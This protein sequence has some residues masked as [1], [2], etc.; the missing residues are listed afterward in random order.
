MQ[1][2][3]VTTTTGNRTCSPQRQA[4]LRQRGAVLVIGLVMLTVTTMLV[5][6]MLKTS[7][8]DLKIGGVTQ[9]A[10]INLNNADVML[11][12]YFSQNTGTFSNRCLVQA[13]LCNAYTAPVGLTTAPQSAVLQ[14]TQIYCGDK[15]GFTGNQV[16]ITFQTAI[17]DASIFITSTL[18]NQARVHIG[19]A[20]D[21]PPGSCT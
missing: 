14:T 2:T 18:Q 8:L 16:G 9:D 11:N 12:T 13:P 20:Q 17:F 5:V 10:M 21:L 15:P 3:A 4:P 1:T 19:I 7:I 6:S